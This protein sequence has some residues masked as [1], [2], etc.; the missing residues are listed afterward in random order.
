MESIK[1]YSFIREI[2]GGNFGKVYLAKNNLGELYAVKKMQTGSI[3][4]RLLTLIN[5]EINALNIINNPSVLRLKES[6]Q[7]SNHI[8]IVMEYCVGGDIEHFI[9]THKKVPEDLVRKWLQ[10][11]ILALHQLRLQN[12]VHRDL[13]LANLMLT[14]SDPEQAEVKIGDFGFAKF[15]GDS[16]TSTQLGTPLYM[17]PEIFNDDQYS[18]KVDIWSLG[19]VAYEMLSGN[20]PFKCYKLEELKRLQK[21]PISFRREDGVSR[22]AEEIVQAMMCYDPNRRVDYEDLLKM[23]F[24]AQNAKEDLGVTKEIE[25]VKGKEKDIDD[26]YDLLDEVYE[27][28]VK[29]NNE[30]KAEE[31]KIEET[32]CEEVKVQEN[33]KT[34]EVVEVE[35]KSEKEIQSLVIQIEGKYNA[36]ASMLNMRSDFSNKPT[37]I[38]CINLYSIRTFELMIKQIHELNQSYPNNPLLISLLGK[39]YEKIQDDCVQLSEDLS[40]IE[41]QDSQVTSDPNN[42]FLQQNII[43]ESYSLDPNDPHS[44]EKAL[45]LFTVGYF[46]YPQN[47]IIVEGLWE[48]SN[49]MRKSRLV[50]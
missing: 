28:D 41:G 2:G 48:A 44:F 6:F 27:E 29:E 31:V 47:E 45:D 39:H 14:H 46:L 34:L 5:N 4:K 18:Y 24:F 19:V 11:L 13:K 21:I 30:V 36:V 26:E 8:Y 25:I 16:L 37:I 3:N 38:Y 15:L 20:A 12:I 7:T 50:G 9:Q 22:D 10:K 49:N 42:L 17:A 40:L 23:R 35:N 1:G 33:P 32:K 43:E